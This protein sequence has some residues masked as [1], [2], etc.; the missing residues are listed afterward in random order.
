M[1]A[2]EQLDQIRANAAL[3][4]SQLRPLSGFDFGL[5][6][7]SVAWVEGFIERQRARGAADGLADVLGSYL[8]EA[9][10]AAGGGADSTTATSPTP[11]RTSASRSGR[12]ST[13]GSRS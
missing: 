10:I 3:V 13:A 1:V 6:E 4:V 7:R 8:G 2:S 12:G 11:L 9:I 5:D